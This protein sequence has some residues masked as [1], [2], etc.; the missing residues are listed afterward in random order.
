MLFKIAYSVHA[1]E[2]AHH[3]HV[4]IPDGSGK[5]ICHEFKF[6]DRMNAML[7]MSEYVEAF[8][9]KKDMVEFHKRKIISLEDQLAL[10]FARL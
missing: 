2:T 9:L 6:I 3:I 8:R 7:A 4:A 5:F 1:E 10:P